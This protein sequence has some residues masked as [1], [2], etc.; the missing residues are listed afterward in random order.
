MLINLKMQGSHYAPN[1][2]IV[3]NV[4]NFGN[5]NLKWYLYIKDR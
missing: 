2:Y 1:N 5:S 4:L 3:Y